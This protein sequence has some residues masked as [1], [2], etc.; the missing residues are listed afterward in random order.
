MEFLTGNNSEGN[1]IVLLVLPA[2]LLQVIRS[3]KC[4]SL[5]YWKEKIIYFYLLLLLL[6]IYF[7]Y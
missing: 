7:I 6:F 4:Y 5:L 3:I 1:S 2:S